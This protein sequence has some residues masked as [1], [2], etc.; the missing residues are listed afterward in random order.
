[1]ICNKCGQEVVTDTTVC[2]HCGASLTQEAMKP[3]KPENV[4]TGTIG[5]IIGAAIGIAVIILFSRLGKIASLSGLILTVCTMKG[6]ELLG[7]QMSIKGIIISILLVIAAPYL[8]DRLDW[9]IVVVQEWGD[10]PLTDAFAKIPEFVEN[11]IINSPWCWR[12]YHRRI[13]FRFYF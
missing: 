7:H 1:M 2:E 5:A 3:V 6:Y 8:A 10:I 4:L 12:R 9:A 11:G 13:H